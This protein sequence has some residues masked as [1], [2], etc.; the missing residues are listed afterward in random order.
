VP[1]RVRTQFHPLEETT[2]RKTFIAAGAATLAVGVAGIA[3]AQTAPSITA[4]ASISPSKAGTKSK[5]KAS[6]FKLTVKNDPASVTT[7]KSITITFPKTLKLSTKG[8]PACT[9]SDD[10]LAGGNPKTLCKSSV[11]GTGSAHANLIPS[12]AVSFNVT[13]LVGKNELLFYLAA[14]GGITNKYVLHGK[15]SGSK[16]TITIPTDVQQPVPGLYSALVDLSTSLKLT[17]GKNTLI[18]SVGC[19]GG[20][21]KVGV[22]IGYA[23]NPNPPTAA[24]ASNSASVKCS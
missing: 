16:L 12:G 15:I 9:Q 5:P 14:T 21:H 11:A 4:T 19:T 23:P 7:A 6:Q 1:R 18:S 3:Y 2:L 13:P 20:A 22:S 8:L 10:A 17:K 24:S